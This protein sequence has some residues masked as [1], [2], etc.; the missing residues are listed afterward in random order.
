MSV[1]VNHRVL[2]DVELVPISGS[3][4]QP[5]GFP[6]I[7]AALFDRPTTVDGA[8]I[9]ESALLVESSQSMA[10]RLEA[11]GWDDGADEPVQTL[12]G[13]PWVRVLAADGT[14]LTSSRT[15]AHRLASA[16][17]KDSKL[18]GVLMTDVI[19]ERL[20]LADDRPLAPRQIAAAVMALDPLCLLHGVFFAESA[21]VWPGQPKIARAITA[22]VEAIDVRRADSGGVKRD[23]VR[24]MMGDDGGSA[25]GYGTIPHHRTE[26]TAAR[27]VASF[28][29]DLEQIRSFGLGDA[30][31]ELLST[32]A[33]W[34]IRSLLD[35]GLRFRTACDLVPVDDVVRDRAGVELASAD[36]LAQRIRELVADCVSDLGSS[37]PIDVVWGA[38]AR[39]AKKQADKENDG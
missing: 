5:T 34:E 10:N 33:L 6:D 2:F 7:G 31:T 26:W 30:A 12:A 37:G 24:H 35:R 29:L 9:W 23:H 4:F 19:R 27:I 3:R 38:G 18:D 13:L 17:V 39:K 1:N 28:N 14:Y 20:R 36:D 25:E 15:E 16:F 8:R 22:F 21:K 11:V 32:V